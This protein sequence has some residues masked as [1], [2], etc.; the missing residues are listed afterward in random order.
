MDAIEVVG[1]RHLTGKVAI[2]G[3]KNA[4]LPMAVASLL[5]PG[6]VRIRN[7]PHLR[8]I[9]TVLELLQ[10][11]GVEGGYEDH[12]LI[13]DASNVRS[14]EAPY[15]LVRQMRASIYVLGPLLAR[16]GKARVSLPGGCAW[17]PRPV[18]LH[19]KGMQM[20]GAEVE[21]DHGYIVARADR[22]TGARIAFDVS[23]VGATGNVMMAAS[24]ARGATRIENAACEP[25]IVALAEFLNAAGARIAGHGTK[26][27]EI[28]GVDALHPVEF[29]NIPDRIETGTFLAAGAIAGGEI[30]CTRTRPDHVDIVLSR[31]REMGC[32]VDSEGDAIRLRRHGPLR[33]ADIRTEV[34]PGFPTDLQAQFMALL[35][36]SQGT[37]VIVET[38]YSD[39]FTHVPELERL[40]A[41]ITLQGNAATVRGVRQLQGTRVMSTDIR[42]SS[43]LI[44]AG[45]VAAG[46]T[47]VS[48]VYHIDRGYERIEEKLRGLGAEVRR[49]RLDDPLA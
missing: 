20:L 31:L 9:A 34:Y 19:I 32:E 23:S 24:L 38:I 49:I 4:A 27:I 40:G 29:E 48:R 13:L 36:V 42:A 10:L 30:V 1:G 35:C 41:R 37:S 18:D 14:T 3:A 28:E 7:V 8:D 47:V 15:D 33:A 26:T 21:L 6:R 12:S 46:T 25:D 11:L 5:I 17:G 16:F 44:L 39:R 45:L 22:L 2:S 43:A